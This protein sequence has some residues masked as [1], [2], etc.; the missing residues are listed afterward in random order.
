MICPTCGA[1]DSRQAGWS[2]LKDSRNKRHKCKQCGRVW[3]IAERQPKLLYFDIETSPVKTWTWGAH[4]R[5]INPDDIIED[6]FVMG[7][8]AKWV[9][10]SSM[11]SYVVNTKEVKKCDDRR[12]MKPLWDLFNEADVIIGHNS[13]RFDIKRVNWRWAIHGYKPPR[14]YKTVDTLKAVRSVWGATS[15]KL[16]YLTKHLGL[17]GKM[18]TQKGLFKKCREGDGAA[19]RELRRYNEVDVLEGE[20]LYLKVRPWMKNHPNMGL[21]Y[22]TNQARCKNCGSQDLDIDENETVKTAVNSYYCW[23]CVNC[24]ANGRT[25]VSARYEKPYPDEDREV[26]RMIAE[27]NREKREN[28]MR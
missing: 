17:D 23:V 10:T 1:D 21:Y 5:Y 11:F 4:K 6:W 3:A 7:W 26:K 2:I 24:G 25:P 16:D 13:D 12:I 9:C 19:L 8:A 20:S 14:P 18:E 27:E 28:L 22:E 15:N